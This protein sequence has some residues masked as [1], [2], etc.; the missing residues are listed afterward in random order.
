MAQSRNSEIL[1]DA[2]HAI[3]ARSSHECTGNFF[4]DEEVL[5]EESVTDLGPYRADPEGSDL[6]VDLFLE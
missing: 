4:I 5:A 2:A 3:L 1:A 6:I